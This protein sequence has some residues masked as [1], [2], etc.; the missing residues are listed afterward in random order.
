MS[1]VAYLAD[2]LQYT[3][4]HVVKRRNVPVS[5]T[6]LETQLHQPFSQYPVAYEQVER[7]VRQVR[8]GIEVL[9]KYLQVQHCEIDPVAYQTYLFE[10]YRTLLNQIGTSYDAIRLVSTASPKER[11]LLGDRLG[12]RPDR[13]DQLYLTPETITEQKLEQIFGLVDTTRNPLSDEGQVD[14]SEG[15][16]IFWKFTGLQWNKDTDLNRKLYITLEVQAQALTVKVYRNENKEPTQLVA[17]GAGI[18]LPPTPD[19]PSP[20]YVGRLSEQNQ[21]GLSGTFQGYL[22]ETELILLMIPVFLRWR[23]EYLRDLWKQQDW[24]AASYQQNSDDTDPEV[25]RLPV[26][27]PDV[28]GPDDF[29]EP[30]VKEAPTDPDRPFDL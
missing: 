12:V 28:I 7:K 23:L 2:L 14:P 22:N 11:Q 27:D 3:M 30:L 20:S 17:A 15:G 21:S 19:T 24:P 6:D 18:Y 29:R 4:T 1:P 13:L 8:I 5:L 9:R 16:G 26:I 10:A 25:D